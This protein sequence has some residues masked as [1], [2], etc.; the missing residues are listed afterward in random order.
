MAVNGWGENMYLFILRLIG[1]ISLW[2]FMMYE[3]QSELTFSLFMLTASLALF[4]FLSHPKVPLYVYWVL[5][6]LLFIHGMIV[7]DVVYTQLLFLLVLI[8]AIFHLSEKW[9]Y[10][11]VGFSFILGIFLAF[12]ERWQIVYVVLVGVFFIVLFVV[13]QRNILK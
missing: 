1:F 12:P 8:I 5:I 2:L 10:S 3:H 11:L 9:F 13:L 4:F 6:G 7:N